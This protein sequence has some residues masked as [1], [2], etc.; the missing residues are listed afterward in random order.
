MDSAFY[1]VNCGG[2]HDHRS[3]KRSEAGHD[4]MSNVLFTRIT[5]QDGACLQ[6]GSTYEVTGG[7][8]LASK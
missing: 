1:N 3:N 6:P 5:G 4:F 7:Y 2:R 8:V